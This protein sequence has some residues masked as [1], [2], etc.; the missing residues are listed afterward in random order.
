MPLDE[1][2]VLAL[3]IFFLLFFPALYLWVEFMRDPTMLRVKN[4]WRA[5]TALL[6]FWGAFA[7]LASIGLLPTYSARYDRLRVEIGGVFVLLI[8]LSAGFALAGRRQ[9]SYLDKRISKFILWVVLL[10][11]AWALLA[12]LLAPAI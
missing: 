6:C 1:Q 11:T 12:L 5:F 10:M 8:G 4:W 3:I 9:Q 2:A 7:T